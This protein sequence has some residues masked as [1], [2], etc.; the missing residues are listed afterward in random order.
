MMVSR[1]VH[2]AS[3]RGAKLLKP[4][5]M[6]LTLSL[7]AVRAT[8]DIGTYNGINGLHLPV[9]ADERALTLA[10]SD[11]KAA[12]LDSALDRLELLLKQNPKFRLAHLIYGDLLMAKARPLARFGSLIQP[13]EPL[14]GL[15]HEAQ[16]RYRH[17][18]NHPP[19]GLLPA[20]L[21]RLADNQRRVV[22]VDTNHSRLYLFENQA[23]KAKLVQDFYVSIGQNGI[24]KQREG[25]KRTPIGVYFVTGR[26]EPEELP[27]LYGR[28]AFPV[29]YPNEWDKRL[30]RTGYG[31]WLHGVPAATYS[32]VP[33]A[34]EGC[35][36]IANSD[37]NAIWRDLDI[38]NTPVI[39]SDTLDWV[40]NRDLDQRSSGFAKV[41]REWRRDWESRNVDAYATHYSLDF[42]GG[43][44]NYAG[45]VKHKR[46]INSRKRF[47]QVDVNNL[48]VFGYP[49]EQDLLVV[50]FDQ[51]YRSDNYANRV[52]K[53][54][55]WRRE[56]D[57]IWRI[58]FEGAA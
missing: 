17:F 5:A 57:G 4:W 28:G 10:L 43:G 11:I 13:S 38:S 56:A 41:F 30:G 24:G 21:L 18:L 46:R 42:N 37:L 1:R 12:R 44:K 32:R 39:I 26:I 15:R 22:V 49:G 52:T 47:I 51:N 33:K 29:N 9:A 16:V 54:Q 34:S 23:G 20:P 40:D 36:A 8:A 7:C 48:S 19:A 25:D 55:Y 2:S 6:F 3:R 27:D 31:I 53:R 14:L 58:I 45:W 50:T 35:L